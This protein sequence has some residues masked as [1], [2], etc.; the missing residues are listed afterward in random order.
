MPAL[1]DLVP[2]E[3]SWHRDCS[4][5]RVV[6]AT[7]QVR[8]W[9]ELFAVAADARAREAVLFGGDEAHAGGEEG[10]AEEV[11]PH[12]L[13][14]GD[15]EAAGNTKPLADREILFL[16]GND[17][18]AVAEEP[19]KKKEEPP[20][21]EVLDSWVIMARLVTDD[22]NE[23]AAVRTRLQNFVNAQMALIGAAP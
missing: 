2:G 19:H 3:V 12:A 7:A 6:V 17:N 10:D 1:P 21:G 8:P 15:G 18:V 16:V 9:E 4:L 5:P 23:E 22:R 11:V 13:V 14:A 20:K